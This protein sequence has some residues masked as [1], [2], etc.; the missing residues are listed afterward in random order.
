MSP[1]EAPA[2]GGVR[3]NFENSYARLPEKF[4]ARVAPTPVPAPRLVK[5]NL[6]LAERLG[7]D[8]AELASPKGVEV[9]AGS[10]VAAGSEPLAMAYAGHQFGYFVRQLGDGRAN[11]LG[12]VI[13]RDGE[14]GEYQSG[15]CGG[16]R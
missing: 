4:Y 13:G 14:G 5:L 10:R 1:T 11:L 8:S 3:F 2:P 9:L 15:G 12:E 7:L 6:E 16:V